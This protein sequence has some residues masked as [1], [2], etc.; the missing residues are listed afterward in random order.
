MHGSKTADDDYFL[1]LEGICWLRVSCLVPG[2]AAVDKAAIEL[3][4]A[5]LL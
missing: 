1:T 2:P 5:H 3:V 4:C